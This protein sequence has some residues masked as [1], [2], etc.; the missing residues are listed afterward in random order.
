VGARA[1]S[2]IRVCSRI[3]SISRRSASANWVSG[4]ATPGPVSKRTNCNCRSFWGISASGTGLKITGS[5]RFDSSTVLST[6]QL[7]RSDLIASG[8]TTNTTVSASCQAAKAF[9]PLLTGS[10]IV[11]VEKWREARKLKTG[12]QLLSKVD[13]APSL[14][15][16]TTLAPPHHPLAGPAIPQRIAPRLRRR[17]AHRP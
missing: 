9:L 6:S 2:P 11:A 16:R 12:N 5:R 3:Q 13:P 7:Q 4:R 1:I 10:D 15:A 14:A 8:E 17:A